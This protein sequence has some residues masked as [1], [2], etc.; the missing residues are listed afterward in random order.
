MA[1]AEGFVACPVKPVEAS[2]W[3]LIWA[4]TNNPSLAKTWLSMLCK[5][6][7]IR[8]YATALARVEILV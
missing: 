3:G 8:I 5:T 7:P 6:G 1:A 2:E 4:R